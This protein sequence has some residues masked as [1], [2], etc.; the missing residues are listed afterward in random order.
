[1]NVVSHE[2]ISIKNKAAFVL[3]SVQ[4]FKVVVTIG[5]VKKDILSLITS[6]YDVVKGPF[7]LYARL[8]CHACD[9]YIRLFA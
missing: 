9:D 1:M 5:F 8:P 7:I 2:H 6:D 3:V 4:P